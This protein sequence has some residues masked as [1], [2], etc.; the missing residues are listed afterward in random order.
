M[1]IILSVFIS[2]GWMHDDALVKVIRQVRHA[3]NLLLIINKNYGGSHD[4]YQQQAANIVISSNHV[5]QRIGQHY[6]I[7]TQILCFRRRIH[8][9]ATRVYILPMRLL[10]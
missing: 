10:E 5:I 1:H 2:L 4:K 9:Y 6:Y 8:T 7:N 3:S